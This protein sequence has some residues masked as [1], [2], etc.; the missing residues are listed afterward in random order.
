MDLDLRN[1]SLLEDVGNSS[2]EVQCDLPQKTLVE[3][4]LVLVGFIGT[5][6]STMSIL[7]NLLLLYMFTTRP[8]FRSTPLYYMS[9]LA[10][11]DIIIC[12]SYILLM[13]VY[14]VMVDY[15]QSLQLYFMVHFYVRPM[16]AISIVSMTA[17]S[18]LMVAAALERCFRTIDR[19][20]QLWSWMSAN[21]RTVAICAV[22]IGVIS[23]GSIFFEM[24]LQHQE[25]CEGTFM[26]YQV[27]LNTELI[28]QPLYAFYRF[29]IRNILTVVLPFIILAVCNAVIVYRLKKRTTSAVIN[30]DKA[31]CHMPMIQ[32]QTERINNH[33]TAVRKQDSAVALQSATR[34]LVLIVLSYLVARSLDVVITVWEYIDDESL[35][36]QDEFYTIAV[37]LISLLTVFSSAFR[38]PIYSLC[39]DAIADELKLIMHNFIFCVREKAFEARNGS[40]TVWSERFLAKSGGVERSTV[41][42]SSPYVDTIIIGNNNNNITSNNNNG[43]PF[44]SVAILSASTAEDEEDENVVLFL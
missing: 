14:N 30:D 25:E 24:H 21:R 2:S 39:N 7:E 18:F 28:S 16:F 12:V 20:R 15:T 29:Y 11:N 5:F 19:T 44:H 8:H 40:L 26:E 27:V 22:L 1:V 6:V 37:D 33:R 32:R 42:S 17:S 34:M 43:S 41:V 4:R 38:L 23:R 13:S 3:L 9:W 31:V 35:L 36:A 10:C